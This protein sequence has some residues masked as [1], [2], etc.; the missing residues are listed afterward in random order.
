MPF[1]FAFQGKLGQVPYALWSFGV[2]LSQH[3]ITLI[4]FKLLGQP[5]LL[6]W[7][8]IPLPMRSF[9]IQ[10]VGSDAILLAV[11]A[12]VS[13]W[14]GLPALPAQITVNADVL[15]ADRSACEIRQDQREV[16]HARNHRVLAVGAALP[17]STGMD[18]NVPD[19]AQFPA[20]ARLPKCA[21]ISAVH[22]YDAGIER[23]GI[24]IVI[25]NEI[26]DPGMGVVTAA[27][28]KSAALPAMVAAAFA[29]FRDEPPPQGRRAGELMPRP[30]KAVRNLRN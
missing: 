10:G 23:M 1:P 24:E 12:Y 11:F 27:K 13:W 17:G 28:Q 2:F 8:F 22:A 5:L 6:D 9:V 30:R 4:A 20:P 26:D 14:P 29:K 25:E 21:E 18:V 15:D 7:H 3:L 16:P 19:D